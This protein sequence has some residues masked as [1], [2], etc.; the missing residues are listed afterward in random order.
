MLHFLIVSFA[1]VLF[2]GMTLLTLVDTEELNK[3]TKE[4]P[5][6]SFK[7]LQIKPKFNS[8]SFSKKMKGA[9][10]VFNKY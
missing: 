10:H 3:A 5:M 2:G 7:D 6:L 9:N 8:V 1:V 4:L